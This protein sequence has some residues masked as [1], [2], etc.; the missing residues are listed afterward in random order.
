MNCRCWFFHFFLF[1]FYFQSV[2]GFT[3]ESQT[4]LFLYFVGGLV[5]GDAAGLRGGCT[6]AGDAGDGGATGVD[7]RSGEALA[8]ELVAKLLG[9]PLSTLLVDDAPV[10][11]T[12]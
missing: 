7:A 6:A 4:L 9:V 5:G 11:A 12:A 8:H 1:L 3:R 10:E 2:L